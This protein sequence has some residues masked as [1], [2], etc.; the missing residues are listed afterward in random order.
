MAKAK[1][2][3][4]KQLAAK[5]EALAARNT[6]VTVPADNLAR[7]AAL[8]AGDVEPVTQAEKNLL[9]SGSEEVEE[10]GDGNFEVDES[11]TV[12]DEEAEATL[13]ADLEEE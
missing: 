11:V 2:L 1:K 10:G 4:K 9:G 3:T 6:N 13:A 8:K 12:S 7:K 5:A